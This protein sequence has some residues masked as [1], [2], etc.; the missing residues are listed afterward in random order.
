[1]SDAFDQRGEGFEKRF[2]MD[3]ELRFKALARRNK[4]LGLWAA[5]RLGHSG[6]AAEA[7]ADA[8]VAAQVGRDDHAVAAAL[9]HDFAAAGVD[10]SA[11]R[12]GRKI[13]EAM[14]EAVA[15]IK[16]GR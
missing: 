14:A 12:I 6:T 16:A 2:V 3:E 15:E 9:A 13:T 10:I 4:A 7:Y 5:E 1:M 8:L 11:H